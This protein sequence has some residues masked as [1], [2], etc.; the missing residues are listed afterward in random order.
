MKNLYTT[1]I[2]FFSVRTVEKSV[3]EGS[4]E[5]EQPFPDY[6]A[7]MLTSGSSQFAVTLPSPFEEE[8]ER[9]DATPYSISVKLTDEKDEQFISIPADWRQKMNAF[10]KGVKLKIQRVRWKFMFFSGTDYQLVEPA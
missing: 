8:N 10:T 5:S 3:V 1:F 9:I 2:N 7:M 4:V 6:A